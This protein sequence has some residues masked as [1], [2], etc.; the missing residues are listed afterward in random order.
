MNFRNWCQ[1]LA[2]MLYAALAGCG[3]GSGGGTSGAAGSN[4]PDPDAIEGS[5]R[6]RY[7]SIG[8]IAAIDSAG[9]VTVNGVTLAT[10]GAAIDIDGRAAA[11]T[12]LR[13]GHVVTVQG[14][15][16]ADSEPATIATTSADLVVAGRIQ[17]LDVA[18]NRFTILGQQ[19]EIDAQTNIADVQSD[20]P[21]GGLA[22]DDDVEVS[23]FTDSS[24]VIF[25]RSIEPRRSTT[26]LIV[27]G[28]VAALDTA[29][30][31]MTIGG[32]PVDY[33]DAT[34]TGFGSV[35]LDGATV[36]VD[37][38][39]VTSGGVLHA[40][41]IVYVDR[42]VP[43]QVGDLVFLEGWVT[44]F[45]ST[46]DFDVD[47]HSV[48]TTAATQT[49]G[50]WDDALAIVRLDAFVSLQGTLIAGGE[51]EATEITTN[52]LITENA[53]VTSV[54]AGGLVAAGRLFYGA[55]KCAFDASVIAV[56]DVPADWRALTVGDRVTIHELIDPQSV[57]PE[58]P[59]GWPRPTR[60]PVCKIV[61]VSHNLRGPVDSIDAA[62]ASLVVMGQRV[63]LAPET[64][65]LGADGRDRH[66]AL[67][68]L[69]PGEPIQVSG[70]ISAEG[71]IVASAITRAP[72][73]DDVRIVNLAQT[74]DPSLRQ[75]Q[76]GALTVDYS[77]ASLAGFGNAGPVAGARVVVIADA[78]P[79]GG[80]LRATGLRNGAAPLRGDFHNLL[81]VNGLTT[82]FDAPDDYDLDGRRTS[83]LAA[84]PAPNDYWTA[85]AC[86]RSYMHA[87][88]PMALL[89]V[90]TGDAGLSQLFT[91]CPALRQTRGFAAGL[92]ELGY[93]FGGI[94]SA[95]RAR[96]AVAGRID[97]VD[98]AKRSFRIGG[99]TVHA[100]PAVLV[101]RV[102][103][104]ATDDFGSLSP[105]AAEDLAVGNVVKF[106]AHLY[107]DGGALVDSIGV[108]DGGGA[109]D[110]VFQGPLDGSVRPDLVIGDVP[111][112]T[113][114]QTVFRHL[115][116][117]S[118]TLVDDTPDDFWS[119]LDAAVA[120]G[121][122]FKLRADTDWDG[123]HWVATVLARID[124]DPNYN[125]YCVQ[126][127]K[128]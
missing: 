51:I 111:V 3:G 95:V 46:S 64:R 75:L 1:A 33:G 121:T 79:V 29:Q 73:S 26:P 119:G 127:G 44:R 25:A 49:S 67:E 91:S 32:Q 77:N 115:D 117:E 56:D 5:G 2:L 123:A 101:S 48:T 8:A 89:A 70:L 96:V 93:D 88:L 50:P 54:D 36:Q 60:A 122:E 15:L 38:D 28:A 52:N 110:T 85:V 22:V 58:P 112:H 124:A 19:V 31:R 11:A 108:P 37:G 100:S 104:P 87:N 106:A 40:T 41:G 84:P 69:Q 35:A 10:T 9:K 23:G 78:P 18:N 120:A 61:T 16:D 113:T 107:G 21:L 128:L 71:E 116:L 13:V 125:F 43:G 45:A 55:E 118:C 72:A 86:E 65:V 20:A 92:Q 74:V 17:A 66:T 24:G 68:S 39:L 102:Y 63:W 42:R 12:E 62:S 114:E 90:R 103:P 27:S 4:G 109:A 83:P 76:V 80:L 126:E 30:K 82:R 7:T 47:G 59:G 105:M 99:L 6:K 81:F 57:R 97:E 94:W 53:L 14:T 98:F 34:L